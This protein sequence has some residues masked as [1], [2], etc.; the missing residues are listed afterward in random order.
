MRKFVVL[1]LFAGVAA[2]GFQGVAS[3]DPP[4]PPGS[5]LLTLT[6]QSFAGG[7]QFT[8]HGENFPPGATGPVI[9]HSDPVELGT[10]TA[11]AS[12]QFTKVFPL[13]CD[14]GPHTATATVGGLSASAS[15]TITACLTNG[16]ALA[17]TGSGDNT[18]TIVGVGLI[19]LLL[20][21]VLVV[22]FTRRRRASLS[23]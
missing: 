20:G 7:G 8:V 3:A 16:R 17:F 22:S 5:P 6:A 2:L 19:A 12:G 18:G 23:A 4:Y 21:A 13:P 15:L 11:D 1:A 10:V 9:L 14:P